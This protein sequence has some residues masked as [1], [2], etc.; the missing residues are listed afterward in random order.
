MSRW[1]VKLYATEQQQHQ[2]E[3]WVNGGKV[4]KRLHDR[5]KIILLCLREKTNLEV[6]EEL[7][8][9]RFTVGKW[10]NRF[11]EK[12]LLGLSTLYNFWTKMLR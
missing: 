7:N 8:M 6:A 9:S 4:E 10:R 5:A 12:G 3:K 2:L 1:A 11:A